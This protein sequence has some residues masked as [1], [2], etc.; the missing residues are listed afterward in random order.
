MK[1]VEKI[2]K[3]EKIKFLD[4]LNLARF[5]FAKRTKY[6]LLYSIIVPGLYVIRTFIDVFES[7]FKKQ[8]LSRNL[9][10]IS[11]A[12]SEMVMFMIM[13]LWWWCVDFCAGITFD[14]LITPIGGIMAQYLLHHMLKTS[15]PTVFDISPSSCE[16]SLS[17]GGKALAKMVRIVFVKV[18]STALNISSNFIYIY[19]SAKPG[20]KKYTFLIMML[21]FL[22]AFFKIYHLNKSI[23]MADE[24]SQ[25]NSKKRKLYVETVDYMQIIKS[26]NEESK[27]ITRYQKAIVERQK[28]VTKSKILEYSNIYVFTVCFSAI[29]TSAM[30]LYIYKLTYDSKDNIRGFSGLINNYHD[31]ICKIPELLNEFIKIYKD[32]TECVVQSQ[33]LSDYM[34]YVQKKSIETVSISEFKDKIEIKNLV[35]FAREKHIF[36]DL[37]FTINKGDRIALYGKNGAGKSSIF[38][39][40]LGYDQFHGSI[41]IDNIDINRINLEEFRE[42]ISFVPQ[43]TKLFDDTIFYNLAYGNDRSYKEVI[44]ECKKMKIHDIIMTF[45]S[46]YNTIVGETGKFLNGGLRQKIFYTRAFLSDSEIFMFDE[47]TNNL[48]THHGSFLMEYLE[49]PKYSDKTFFVITHDL[50][51]IKKM[52]KILNFNDGKITEMTP[53]Y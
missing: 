23:K 27:M 2:E 47:P 42:L 40:I 17:E 32:F 6:I 5:F 49:D 28:A 1:E 29:S 14:I 26:S 18:L 36:S 13:K 19:D 31:T 33:R 37:N 24:A 16:Y 35:Y 4:S 46:G 41:L 12:P 21:Y 15:N 3:I 7:N 53:N 43:D 30:I 44:D 52:P 38:K 9:P 25:L 20:D 50:E 8:L 34:V 48:D 22:F 39:L 11:I 10:N 51:I 45:P